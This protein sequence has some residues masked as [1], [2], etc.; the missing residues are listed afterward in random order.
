MV[1]VAPVAA[2]TSCMQITVHRARKLA[3]RHSIASKIT[4]TLGQSGTVMIALGLLL[5][6]TT[7][8][9]ACIDW[10]SVD[11]KKPEIPLMDDLDVFIEESQSLDI[12]VSYF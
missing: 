6:S 9:S 11:L 10:K 1:Q 8:A 4:Q 7:F 12:Q 2:Q 3:T 5:L